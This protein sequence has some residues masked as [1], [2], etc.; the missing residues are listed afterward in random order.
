MIDNI[1]QIIEFIDERIDDE[2]TEREFRTPYLSGFNEG[3]IQALE[4]V[5]SFIED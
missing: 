5:K 2:T 3:F 1:E 4:Q